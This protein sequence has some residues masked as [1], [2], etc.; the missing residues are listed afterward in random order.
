MENVKKNW[1]RL[2]KLEE[3]AHL[4][5]LH[6]QCIDFFCHTGVQYKNSNEKQGVSLKK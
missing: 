4:K 6:T 3:L 1:V 2:F 5:Q